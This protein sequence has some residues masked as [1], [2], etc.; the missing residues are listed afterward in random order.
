MTIEASEHQGK[1]IT[2]PYRYDTVSDEEIQYRAVL[3]G[4]IATF[5]SWYIG[6][7]SGNLMVEQDVKNEDIQLFY[8]CIN[9]LI[10]R[11]EFQNHPSTSPDDVLS[12]DSTEIVDR[13]I[14]LH[15]HTNKLVAPGD[16]DYV[17]FKNY[18]ESKGKT[19]AEMITFLQMMITKI[20]P[21]PLGS[22]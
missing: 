20:R 8:G 3:S 1:I 11:Y 16:I 2:K 17:R 5:N 22:N 9:Q 10:P 4:I 6:H 15:S 12:L 19:V 13:L 14:H 18:V 21:R 7:N